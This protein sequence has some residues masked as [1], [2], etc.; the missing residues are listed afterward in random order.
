M[1]S[2]QAARRLPVPRGTA[3]RVL[4]WL[5]IGAGTLALLDAGTTLVWQ[6]P[7]SALYARLQQDR[8]D[9]TLRVL[10]RAAPTP[11]QERTLALL[12][13]ERQRIDF[14]A[15][16]L[17]RHSHDGGAVGR[18]HIARLHVDFVVVKGTGEEELRKGPGVYDETPFPGIGGTTAIA[19][20]RTT[21]LA[22]FRHI[23]ALRKGD[24]IV[25]KM[26]YGRFTYAVTG[27]RVVLPSDVS[28]IDPVPYTQL[29]LSACTPP[30]SASHR[31][32]V[33]A[34][35]RSIEPLGA[36][37]P[38]VGTSL[39]LRFPD[40]AEGRGRAAS[41]SAH[42]LPEVFKPFERLPLSLVA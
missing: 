16:E 1:S 19:G 27:W 10:E 6:E 42:Q 37:R 4:A 24:R 31:L 34:R 26:P 5:L 35:L 3:L 39:K 11:L 15:W 29:V 8:L 13:A 33:F 9:G 41:R 2:Q 22:P 23:D 21:Y 28:V 40:G 20:H 25:V 7:L 14:L 36:A 17:R 32:V 30:F 38:P 12:H 18:I